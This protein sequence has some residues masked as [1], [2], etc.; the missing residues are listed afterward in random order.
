MTATIEKM[1]QQQ[2]D[3][4][5]ELSKAMQNVICSCEA[6][7]EENHDLSNQMTEMSQE[8]QTAAEENSDLVNKI[9]VMTEEFHTLTERLMI[10][11]GQNFKLRKTIWKLKGD[12]NCT[13]D[14]VGWHSCGK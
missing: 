6:L 12:F 8:L 4:I 14:G 1:L 7:S 3:I 5:K 10:L 11:E 2:I 9:D 13:C